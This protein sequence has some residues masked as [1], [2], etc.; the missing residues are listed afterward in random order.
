MT[1]LSNIV[2]K[3]R[4]VFEP[5]M[6]HHIN[7]KTILVIVFFVYAIEYVIRGEEPGGRDCRETVRWTVEQGAFEAGL[8]EAGERPG[9]RAPSGAKQRD[10]PTPILKIFSRE[11]VLNFFVKGLQPKV[12]FQV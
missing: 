12:Y 10:P 3:C 11:R 5:L 1:S 9:A 6:V 7:E 2:D 4:L 8:N